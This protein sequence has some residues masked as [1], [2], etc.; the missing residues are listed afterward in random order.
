MGIKCNAPNKYRRQSILKGH[1]ILIPN[2][3][4][5]T[6]KEQTKK[7]ICQIESDKGEKETAFFCGI[8][9]PDNYQQLPVLITS[10]KIINNNDIIKGK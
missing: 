4:L 10:N 9:F 7:G 8:P 3:G 5:L 6:I 1:P 2:S